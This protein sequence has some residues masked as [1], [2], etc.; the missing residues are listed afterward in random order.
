MAL[1]NAFCQFLIKVERQGLLW[2]QCWVDDEFAVHGEL[3]L[4]SCPG[5]ISFNYLFELNRFLECFLHRLLPRL[6]LQ[7][8]C[9]RDFM[10]NFL[11]HLYGL[12]GL[13]KILLFFVQH[14]SNLVLFGIHILNLD[15]S[16]NQLSALPP[17]IT[18]LKE[19]HQCALGLITF[20]LAL[21][22]RAEN[23]MVSHLWRK[24]TAVAGRRDIAELEGRMVLSKLHHALLKLLHFGLLLMG[25]VQSLRAYQIE[26]GV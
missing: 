17:L 7:L 14:L 3:V 24:L 10:V 19:R 4:K 1:S 5:L 23:K 15:L 6:L 18:S 16:G 11:L 26:L 12:P 9:L 21:R 2:P 13:L 22:R 25:F 20:Q 8:F